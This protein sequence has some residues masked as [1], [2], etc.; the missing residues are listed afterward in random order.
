MK[1][2]KPSFAEEN[3][4]REQ[5]Y[6]LIAG[7]DEVGRG[8]LVGP[9][10]AAAV[11]MPHRIKQRWHY[12]VRD[13]KQLS[14]ARR[15]FLYNRIIEVAVCTGVGESSHEVIDTQGIVQATRS[16]MKAAIDQLSTKPQFLLIDYLSLPEVT[17]PH[18]GIANGDS[19]CFSIACA[20]I[21]AKVTRDR[22]MVEMDGIYPDYGLARHKGYG[23][24]EH[25]ACLQK[26][27]PC[28][29]HRRSFRPVSEVVNG[30][31]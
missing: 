26:M 25:L 22:M 13:S 30:R 9:V 18:R 6:E 20:S 29:F 14:P 12:E 27:G 8:A 4:L 3:Q 23:T 1:N 15:E 28:P 5:G 11:I 10:V 24:K 31:I 21:V 16:A 7:V 2:R 17:V 19:L